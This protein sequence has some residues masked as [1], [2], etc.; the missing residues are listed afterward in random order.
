MINQAN[1]IP[2]RCPV[3]S[4]KQF[5]RRWRECNSQIDA[6]TLDDDEEDAW[7]TRRLDLLSSAHTLGGMPELS[8]E[9]VESKFGVVLPRNSRLIC[10]LTRGVS[11]TLHFN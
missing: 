3:L 4:S 5:A 11:R 9:V 1:P 8:F 10:Q 7:R 2:S 6:P